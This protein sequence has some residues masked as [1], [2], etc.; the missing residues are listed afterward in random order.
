MGP[1]FEL[2]KWSHNKQNIKYKMYFFQICKISFQLSA[3]L[4]AISQFRKHIDYFKNKYG[5]SDLLFEHSA[6]MAKQYVFFFID[7]Y[8][9]L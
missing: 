4:D 5:Q 2:Y 8:T 1:F 6:W 3:P 9:L 7:D